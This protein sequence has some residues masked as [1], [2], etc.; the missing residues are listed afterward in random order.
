MPREIIRTVGVIA[1]RHWLHRDPQLAVNYI[2]IGV[3]ELISLR[4]RQGQTSDDET[5]CANQSRLSSNLRHI[6]IMCFHAVCLLP[7]GQ[8]SQFLNELDTVC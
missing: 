7:V 4:S 5:N 8:K 1:N 6:I 2:D 3:Y